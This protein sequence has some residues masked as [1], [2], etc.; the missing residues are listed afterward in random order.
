[1]YF[2]EEKSVEAINQRT[3]KT[4]IMLDRDLLDEIDRYNPFSTRKEFL[5]Q[6]CRAYLIELRRRLIDERLA[7]ACKEA[8][9]ED[10]AVNE[11]WEGITL[12]GWR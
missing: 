5:N 2:R 11:E 4:T 10:A 12:E 3:L 9:E 6:A 8:G 7:E 1:M